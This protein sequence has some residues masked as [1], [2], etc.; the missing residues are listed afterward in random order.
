MTTK[1]VVTANTDLMS[2]FR[3]FQSE[4][5]FTD[6]KITGQDS[7]QNFN[8]HR[9]VMSAASPYL[10]DLLMDPIRQ[11]EDDDPVSILIPDMKPDVLIKFAY[12][13]YGGETET[14][15]EHEIVSWLKLLG[16]PVHKIL[17]KKLEA[18]KD[19][20]VAKLEEDEE[21]RTS[22]IRDDPM[23][24]RFQCPF[25]SCGIIFSAS[26]D[27]EEHLAQEHVST[28]HRFNKPKIPF[29]ES[30]PDEPIMI[31]K[32]DDLPHK[33]PFCQKSFAT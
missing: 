25:K 27:M 3:S 2:D 30:L 12:Y 8:C 4:K 33:C 26:Q 11:V 29:I 31:V 21:E 24:L 18:E 28:N 7:T 6:M 20:N 1:V 14:D 9:L 19:S 15:L 5:K 32:S 13:V 10:R 23:T 22:V 17:M 16:I